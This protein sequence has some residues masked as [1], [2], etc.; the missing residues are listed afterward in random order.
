MPRRRPLVTR[1]GRRLGKFTRYRDAMQY[2]QD[3]SIRLM[4]MGYTPHEIAE[5]VKLP[6]AVQVE[7]W[8]IE[9]YG[10]VDVSARNV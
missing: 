7:P 10:N 3:Q 2:V 9:Y 6:K 4:N 8:G 1:S 5:T